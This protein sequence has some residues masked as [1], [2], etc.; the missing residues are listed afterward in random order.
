LG[1]ADDTGITSVFL[2]EDGEKAF[3]TA[4]LRKPYPVII[5]LADNAVES[6]PK[7]FPKNIDAVAQS[8]SSQQFVFKNGQNCKFSTS[9][10]GT[11]I[12]KSLVDFESERKNIKKEPVAL[13]M[14]K[15]NL[16]Y[17]VWQKEAKLV[18]K[19]ITVGNSVQVEE[20]DLRTIYDKCFPQT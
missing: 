14:P 8:P 5:S 16:V 4:N 10:F 17:A 3:L 20:M 6:T 1:Y 18:L 19:K 7:G 11:G 13:A 12:V 2:D 15:E 9:E